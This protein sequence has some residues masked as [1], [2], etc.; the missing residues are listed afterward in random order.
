[1]GA[2]SARV[3]PKHKVRDHEGSFSTPSIS[4]MLARGS[5][6]DF[7]FRISQSWIRRGHNFPSKG[8]SSRKSTLPKWRPQ[9]RPRVLPK[10]GFLHGGNVCKQP[11]DG[12]QSSTLLHRFKA[13]RM[14]RLNSRCILNPMH[15]HWIRTN[16][17]ISKSISLKRHWISQQLQS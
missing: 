8:F 4:V 1:M 2:R 16:P 3:R 10:S 7:T 13:I 9:P 14:S 12:K 5:S 17:D 11:T 15:R 6:Q